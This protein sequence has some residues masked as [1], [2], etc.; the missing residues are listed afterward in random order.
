MRAGHIDHGLDKG[1]RGK[2]LSGTALLILA[3]LLKDVLVNGALNVAIHH[4]PGFLI[5][6]SNDLLEINRLV[7]FVLRLSVNG[8]DEVLLFAEYLQSLLVLVNQVQTIQIN[9]VLPAVA[10]RNG[11]FLSEHFHVLV[12]H[13]QEEEVGKLGYVIRKTNALPGKDIGDLPHFID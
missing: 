10:L 9:Q 3:V 1:A 5:D 4:Q 12:I 7:N 8:T 13:F 11:G 6:E 2:I